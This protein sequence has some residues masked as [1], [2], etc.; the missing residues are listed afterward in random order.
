MHRIPDSSAF[1]KEPNDKNG[2]EEETLQMKKK[3]KKR[4]KMCLE[5]VSWPVTLAHLRD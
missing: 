3:K 4:T 1:Y 2:F 5:G